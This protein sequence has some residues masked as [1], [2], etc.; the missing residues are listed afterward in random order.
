[1]LK[2]VEKSVIFIA[3]LVIAH[4]LD[5]ENP[6]GQ[7]LNGLKNGSFLLEMTGTIDEFLLSR[8]TERRDQLFLI[9]KIS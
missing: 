9:P 5:T 1:M 2:A 7:I 3:L 4:F 6:F 8:R